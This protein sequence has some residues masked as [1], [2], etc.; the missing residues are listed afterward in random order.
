[1]EFSMDIRAE[2]SPTR[3]AAVEAVSAE[4]RAIAARRNLGVSIELM[5]DLAE[6]PCDPGLTRLL[7]EAVRA[8]GVEP[9]RL[10]SGAG[11]DAMVIADIAPT[12]M[13]FIRCKGGVSHNPAESVRADDCVTALQATLA[14]I[15][16]LERD[17]RP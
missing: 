3:D 1:V 5:Q 15:D 9:R 12:A 10:P 16:N 17:Y 14:F 2:T 4:I 7:E 8:T 11:H 13:L 6:S